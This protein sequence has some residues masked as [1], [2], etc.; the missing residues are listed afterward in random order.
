MDFIFIPNPNFQSDLKFQN[1]GKE[2]SLEIKHPDSN[3]NIQ[4]KCGKII[5]KRGKYK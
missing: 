4:G 2:N 5:Q 1:F 3:I